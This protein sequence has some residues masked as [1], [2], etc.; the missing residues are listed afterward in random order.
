MKPL[1]FFLLVMA[2][3]FGAFTFGWFDGFFKMLFAFIGRHSYTIG[4]VFFS[5]FLLSGIAVIAV[6]II[7]KKHRRETSSD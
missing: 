5:A 2:F 6:E 1:A 4:V 3:E 7:Q